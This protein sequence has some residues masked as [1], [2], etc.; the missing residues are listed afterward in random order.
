MKWI[1]SASQ[2]ICPDKN[3]L[4][5]RR[6]FIQNLMEVQVNDW[7][8]IAERANIPEFYL[9]TSEDDIDG[10]FITAHIDAVYQL[11]SQPFIA[12]NKFIIANTCI[13]EKM[14]DKMVLYNLKRINK[15]AELWFAKQELSLDSNM[16]FHEST[17][18]S[19]EG[20]FGFMSSTSERR[21]FVNRKKGFM[22]AV[23]ESFERVS[24]ILLSKDYGVSI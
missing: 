9:C 24:P 20:T 10:I 6:E 11:S 17:L 4:L 21:L 19:E 7:R 1:I 14:A 18:L 3:Q 15:D 8:Y 5:A 2:D 13:W 12:N 16:F 22:K 23:Q